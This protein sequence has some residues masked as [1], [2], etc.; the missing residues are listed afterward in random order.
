MVNPPPLKTHPPTHTY[1]EGYC[2]YDI[3]GDDNDTSFFYDK[4]PMY[5]FHP[6][7][8]NFL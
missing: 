6:T 4:Q 8:T 3:K 7:K 5:D 1:F 2:I